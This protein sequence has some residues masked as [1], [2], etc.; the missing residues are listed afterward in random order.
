MPSAASSLGGETS[1]RGV[2]ERHAP[3]QQRP[4]K[5]ERV[6]AW[7]DNYAKLKDYA[8]LHG[9]ACP[10]HAP[11]LGYWASGQRKF[12]RE[13]ALEEARA[14]KLRAIGF[15]FDGVEACSM[16][17]KYLAAKESA[18]GAEE[19]GENVP[20]E[21]AR[22]SRPDGATAGKAV[23]PY[24]VCE[25]GEVHHF[26]QCKN[27]PKAKNISASKQGSSLQHHREQGENMVRKQQQ[28]Q[29]ESLGKHQPSNLAQHSAKSIVVHRPQRER[30]KVE[31]MRSSELRSVERTKHT[32][33]TSGN[34]ALGNGSEGDDEEEALVARAG[35]M[36]CVDEDVTLSLQSALSKSAPE[37]VD[38][39]ERLA[40]EKDGSVE[41]LSAGADAEGAQRERHNKQV[42]RQSWYSDEPDEQAGA[43]SARPQ[44]HGEEGV[45][46]A[47]SCAARE[48]TGARGS[49]CAER[50]A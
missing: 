31:R 22:S 45:H 29:P 39:A 44:G 24:K 8:Q 34:N 11:G 33:M 20:G 32:E 35:R 43:D 38:K 30:K 46:Q 4:A 48:A 37:D 18:S 15:L 2:E 16:R 49:G 21:R 28:Q 27:C 36:R 47:R 17:Q 50:C 13:G 26:M 41:M 5:E 7:E 10:A 1:V 6:T 3:G 12:Y 19:K 40:G 25:C 9:H 14:A 23:W 42:V